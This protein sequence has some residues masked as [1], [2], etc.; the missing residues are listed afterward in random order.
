MTDRRKIESDAIKQ[1]YS[2]EWDRKQAE[3]ARQTAQEK[4]MAHKEAL[5]PMSIFSTPTNNMSVISGKLAEP[6]FGKIGE[7][8][9]MTKEIAPG[10][11]GK[12]EG[13]FLKMPEKGPEADTKDIGKGLMDKK[14]D[15]PIKEEP[16]MA[17]PEKNAPDI[18]KIIDS[19]GK[20]D[21]PQREMEKMKEMEKMGVP[22]PKDAK[23]MEDLR[24][25][26]YRP[27]GKEVP[28]TGLIDSILKDLSALQSMLGKM[29]GG[30]GAGYTSGEIC[31]ST[32][33]IIAFALIITVI[34]AT[35]R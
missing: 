14:V 18:K 12:Q 33:S 9:A 8:Q 3:I 29:V 15:G 10:G 24:K 21:V 19:F 35:R 2:E 34:L 28:G 6:V 13:G 17:G 25:G 23:D 5:A 1:M 26:L 27:E 30:K 16:K 4:S 32:N 20:P 7:V 31:G 11:M 22:P